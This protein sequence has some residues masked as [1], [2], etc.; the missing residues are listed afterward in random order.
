MM[1]RG[2]DDNAAAVRGLSGLHG[3]SEVACAPMPGISS[4]MSP[5]MARTCAIYVREGGADDE[6]RIDHWY[7][8]RWRLLRNDFDTAVG[9]R[10]EKL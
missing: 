10:F 4:G 9:R 3:G 6:G 8:I 7:S 2:V 5:T 1:A